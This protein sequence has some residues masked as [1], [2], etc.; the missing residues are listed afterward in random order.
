MDARFTSSSSS[1][2]YFYFTSGRLARFGIGKKAS[3]SSQEARYRPHHL[4]GSAAES[5]P[6]V[7]TG[8]S[9]SHAVC[10]CSKRVGV[11]SVW[12]WLVVLRKQRHLP[13]T[14]VNHSALR[15]APCKQAKAM[16]ACWAADHQVI[17]AFPIVRAIVTWT[18]TTVP[19]HV[20]I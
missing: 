6:S 18:R 1:R 13:R 10:I 17:Q 8:S 16:P 5:N 4:Q 19:V 9:C 11:Q 14:L 2:R 12:L 3:S 7:I 20:Y 15:P